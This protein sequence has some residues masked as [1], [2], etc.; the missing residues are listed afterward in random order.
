MNWV[1]LG[2]LISW[3]F[4]L[5][6]CQWL[7]P[8]NTAETYTMGIYLKQSQRLICSG[9][10]VNR[11][12]V[13]TARHCLSELSPDA[14]AVRW[15]NQ[16]RLLQV[17][18]IDPYRADSL[19]Y[20]NFDLVKL[21]LAESLPIDQ[22]LP[23]AEGPSAGAEYIQLSY[24][25]RFDCRLTNECSNQLKTIHLS[26]REELHGARLRNLLALQAKDDEFACQKDSGGPVFALKNGQLSLLALVVGRWYPVTD[27]RKIICQDPIVTYTK[28]GPYRRWIEG[29]ETSRSKEH[30]LAVPYA[31]L[32]EACRRQTPQVE[33]WHTI[34][35]ILTQLAGA[36]SSE[37]ARSMFLACE[38]VDKAWYEYVSSGATIHLPARLPLIHFPF[39]RAVRRLSLSN[40][41]QSQ[42]AELANYK[43]LES[44]SVIGGDADLDISVLAGLKSL[45]ELQLKHLDRIRS[46]EMLRSLDQLKALSLVDLSFEST[47]L[48]VGEIL[49]S[50]TRLSIRQ[51]QIVD[52]PPT[53]EKLSGSFQLTWFP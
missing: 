19:H 38:G 4:W 3:V 28:L 11:D 42:I 51:M 48:C 16:G 43:D 41:S 45:K 25:D 24:G 10:A 40:I 1:N 52:C 29:N 5:G 9:V 49:P 32:E 7:Q 22:D 8:K 13:L 39:L 12:T 14:Y 50:L 46:F 15:Q 35:S 33:G 44:L 30:V 21:V 31:S 6:S 27:Q 17:G 2:L 23:I 18:S 47:K 20:P 53:R 26:V 34:Q 37:E 36:S